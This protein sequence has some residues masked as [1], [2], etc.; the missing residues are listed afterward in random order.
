MYASP[1]TITSTLLD[2]G[3]RVSIGGYPHLCARRRLRRPE[4]DVT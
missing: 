2:E 3:G 4:M 1:L